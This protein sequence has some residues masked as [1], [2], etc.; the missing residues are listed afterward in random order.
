MLH[1]VFRRFHAA[2]ISASSISTPITLL[3]PHDCA[4]LRKSEP[5]IQLGKHVQV[6]MD[7]HTNLTCYPAFIAPDIQHTRIV[8]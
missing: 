7:M 3:A 5:F 2:R 4:G 6:V 8:K 1:R